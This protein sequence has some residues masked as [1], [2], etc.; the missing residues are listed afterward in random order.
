MRCGY[1][2]SGACRQ[3]LGSGAVVIITT[4]AAAANFVSTAQLRTFEL[5]Q[6]KRATKASV[7]PDGLH[8]RIA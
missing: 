4:A 2:G 8:R 3:D 6:H 1:G 5:G 7:D